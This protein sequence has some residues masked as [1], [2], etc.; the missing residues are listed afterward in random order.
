MFL[1][2]KSSHESRLGSLSEQ[3]HRPRQLP[4][5]HQGRLLQHLRVSLEICCQLPK[6]VFK[7]SFFFFFFRYSDV[8]TFFK[9]CS[10][11]PPERRWKNRKL[12]FC[13]HAESGLN[14]PFTT[15]WSYL[16]VASATP[17]VSLQR[18]RKKSSP[19]GKVLTVQREDDKAVSFSKMELEK[20]FGVLKIRKPPT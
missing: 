14:F 7:Q 12:H 19:P 8:C 4:P 3:W 17:R 2:D 15:C 6:R 20:T 10:F 18:A 5:Q 11:S 1:F 9:L 13:T 16:S